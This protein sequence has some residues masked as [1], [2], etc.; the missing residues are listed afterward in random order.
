ME[1]NEYQCAY[2]GR[3]FEKGTPDK[4]AWEEHDHNFPGESHETAEIICDDCYQAMIAVKPPPGMEE[5]A[6]SDIESQDIPWQ[7]FFTKGR[8]PWW[9]R[10]LHQKENRKIMIMFRATEEVIRQ[11]TE[12]LL[13]GRSPLAGVVGDIRRSEEVKHWNDIVKHYLERKP[14]SS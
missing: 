2:C 9:W 7:F 13:Y 14:K 1:D 11:K 12:L 6:S 3:V 4:E 8:F 5:K 10:L